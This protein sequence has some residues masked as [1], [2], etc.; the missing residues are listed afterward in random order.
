MQGD[1]TPELADSITIQQLKPH[2]V[3]TITEPHD[4]QSIPTATGFPVSAQVRNTGNATAY[5]VSLTASTESCACTRTGTPQD[6]PPGAIATAQ[7]TFTCGTAGAVLLTVTAAGFTDCKYTTAIPADNIEPHTITIYLTESQSGSAGTAASPSITPP[8]VQQPPRIVTTYVHTQPQYVA[9][10]Q[11]V[12]VFFNMANR[13]DLRGDYTA[14]LKING[15]VEQVKEGSLEG[16]S[17][18]PL[19]FTVSAEK[20]GKYKIDI[21]GQ[22]AYFI[23][24]DSSP[25]QHPDNTAIFIALFAVLV[26]LSLAVLCIRH[27]L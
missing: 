5:N 26:A 9:A 21:N 4:G 16:H 24:S 1:E 20:P 27:V 15:E 25:E 23:V 12:T 14:T 13:G 6:I 2:L 7:W 22:R 19:Q 11:P 8:P 10:S 3:V 18:R 17:A